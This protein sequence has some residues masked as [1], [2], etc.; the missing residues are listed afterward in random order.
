MSQLKNIFKSKAPSRQEKTTKIIS[1]SFDIP[2]HLLD[3]LEGFDYMLG[4]YFLDAQ[5]F[6][7]TLFEGY[8]AFIKSSNDEFKNY[9]FL[10]SIKDSVSENTKNEIYNSVIREFKDLDFQN[11]NVTYLTVYLDE[12]G[13]PPF[14]I[15]YA[16]HLEIR[17]KTIDN[18]QDLN[19]DN[20]IPKRIFNLSLVCPKFEHRGIYAYSG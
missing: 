20:W 16:K 12:Q 4:S 7:T 14:K 2:D 9:Q 1:E 8:S 11:A 13:P 15:E 10:L 19:K 3:N 6:D 17:S 18:V 5:Y